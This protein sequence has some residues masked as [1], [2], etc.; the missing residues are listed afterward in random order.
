MTKGKEKKRSLLVD[1]RE[2][3]IKMRTG[4]FIMLGVGIII[5]IFTGYNIGKELGLGKALL[6]GVGSAV[7]L[8]VLFGGLYLFNRLF[9]SGDRE[10]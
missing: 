1:A 10:R 6:W 3:W 7:G 4:L 2:P 8:W 5:G 9:R